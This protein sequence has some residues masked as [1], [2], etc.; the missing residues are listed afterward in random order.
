MKILQ[1]SDTPLMD[2]L[3]MHS[4]L[5]ELQAFQHELHDLSLYMPNGLKIKS[6][7]DQVDEVVEAAVLS[8]R[9]TARNPLNEKHE[10]RG[11]PS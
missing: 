7:H 4:L 1:K 2:G 10:T 3:L 5:H 8:F 9:A 6:L 11:I